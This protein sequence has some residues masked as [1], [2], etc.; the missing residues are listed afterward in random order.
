MLV[1]SFPHRLR[2]CFIYYLC[3]SVRCLVSLFFDVFWAIVEF[4]SFPWCRKV[5]QLF[6]VRTWFSELAQ[7]RLRLFLRILRIWK[8]ITKNK[9]QTSLQNNTLKIVSFDDNPFVSITLQN[10]TY[11]NLLVWTDLDDEHLL[12]IDKKGSQIHFRLLWLGLH[13][14]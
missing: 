9:L 1:L 4:K 12:F 5:N 2:F 3:A 10:F 8:Q 13:Y 14:I 6:L 11:D 7:F